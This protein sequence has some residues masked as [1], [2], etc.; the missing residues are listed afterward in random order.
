MTDFRRPFGFEDALRPPVDV[1]RARLTPATLR[2]GRG[3]S[4]EVRSQLARVVRRAP[5]VM[6]KVTGRTGDG[7]HLLRH[8]DYISRNGKLPLEG[9][10]GERLD[11]RAEVRAL[12]E[13]WIAELALEPGRRKDSAMSLSVVLSMPKGVEAYRVQDAARAFASHTFGDRHPYVFAL[14]DEGAHPHVHLSIRMLGDDGSRLNPRKADLQAWREAFAKELR[15]RAVEAEATPR[16]ARGV[17]R[18]AERTPIRKMRERFMER[19]GPLPE[20]LQKALRSG[21]EGGGR[22]DWL[23]PIENRQRD[24]RRAYVAESLRLA[25]SSLE[26]DRMLGRALEAFVR[27]MPL[28]ETRAQ[29]IERRI[30]GRREAILETGRQVTDGERPRHR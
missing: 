15:A 9:P 24:I 12:V 29:D 17:V 2:G 28:P 21:L 19:R 20:S 22:T 3:S 8:L 30:G 27:S 11:G 25:R 7:G 26:D 14:H 16:R 1:R 4:T 18:K 23:R 5:E 6:V 13:D 10:D